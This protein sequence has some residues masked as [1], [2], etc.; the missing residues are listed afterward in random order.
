MNQ[1]RH[2]DV[3]LIPAAGRT[4]PDY[5]LAK[6]MVVLAEGVGLS[7]ERVRELL[8]YDAETGVFTHRQYRGGTARQGDKAGS[9]NSAGYNLIRV[10]GKKYQASRLAYLWMTGHWPEAEMDH[11]NRV[12]TDDRWANLRAVIRSEQMRNRSLPRADGSI[13][14]GVTP[15][16]N[17]WRAKIAHAGRT[18]YLGLFPTKEAAA[19]AYQSKMSEYAST[20]TVVLAWGEQTG[21]AHRVT[22]GTNGAVTLG[23]VGSA[24]YMIV[25]D[26]PATL[27]HEE[28][29][30]VTIPEGTYE[31]R[32][33]RTW[34]YLAEMERRVAD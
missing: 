27:D 28:H 4:I 23:Q 7:A 1:I 31:V 30:P 15:H 19:E 14:V 6:P 17:K 34:D 8:D 11:I 20:R 3:F 9:I 2:G 13:P 24:T 32:I 26:A 21:H 5:L 29:G 16:H 18:V 12:R 22:A 25:T 33:Q 10:D